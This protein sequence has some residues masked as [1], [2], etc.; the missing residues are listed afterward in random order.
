MRDRGNKNT[1]LDSTTSQMSLLDT[2]GC[3]ATFVGILGRTNER[4]NSLAVHSPPVR[5]RSFT[6]F[7]RV[8]LH[9]GLLSSIAWPFI[10]RLPADAE[11]IDGQE[12][13]ILRFNDDQKVP[14]SIYF[15]KS[16]IDVCAFAVERRKT[17][18]GS[19]VLGDSDR[20]LGSCW[21]RQC[22]LGHSHI[23]C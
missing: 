14:T 17:A 2:S 19:T 12:D 6:A 21:I 18:S 11:R 23:Y 10:C 13:R 8:P 20:S 4:L 1:L 22:A 15:V 9:Q 7:I 3:F 16:T 5:H